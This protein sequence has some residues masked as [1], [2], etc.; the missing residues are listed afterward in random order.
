M[1]FTDGFFVLC[2][3]AAVFLIGAITP[4]NDPRRL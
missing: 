4:E 1:F 3:A 2:A